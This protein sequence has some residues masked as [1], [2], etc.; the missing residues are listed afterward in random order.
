MVNQWERA[1][2]AWP[3]LTRTAASKTTITYGELSAQLGLPH[4]RPLRYA[5]DKIHEYCLEAG[6]PPLT[7]VVVSR[8]S[9][10]PGAGFTAW[11]LGDWE[12]GVHLVYEYPWSLRLNPFAFAADGST[13]EQ[14]AGQ[15]IDRPE[16][17]A[18]IYGRIR[19]RGSAQRIFRLALLKAY[20]GRCAFCGLSL[21]AALEAAH[22]IPW[23]K[24]SRAERVLPSNGLLL[25][26]THHALF[27]ASVLSVSEDLRIACEQ[28]RLPQHHW[29][30]ADRGAALSL[31][32]EPI[33]KPA[34]DRH[35]P[36]GAAFVRR[37]GLISA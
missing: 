31:D 1:A 30:E 26:S 16:D 35:R 36:S 3:I 4:H 11:D 25:C 28:S 6:L 29:N 23:S 17:A 9:G 37:V 7:I 20:Q 33:A 22:I 15:L 13:P 24:A 8:A 27:D 2:R 10:H 34:D 21:R 12:D 18:E 19:D 14:L 32:G 5:L